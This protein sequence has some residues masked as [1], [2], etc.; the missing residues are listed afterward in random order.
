M[1]THQT[2]SANV[3]LR[4]IG[5]IAVLSVVAVF[6]AAMMYAAGSDQPEQARS[7]EVALNYGPPPAAA[8]PNPLI[9][10]S[11]PVESLDN[12]VPINN[13]FLM[14]IM[15]TDLD[16]V[17]GYVGFQGDFTFDETVVTF[18]SPFVEPAGLTSSGWFVSGNVLDGPG[19]IRILRVSAFSGQLIPLDGE[20]VLYN[21]R[22]QRVSDTPG[23][24]SPLIWRI[25]PNGFEYIDS[26]LN[27]VLPTQSQGR[28]TISGVGPTAT[29]T[30][31]PVPTPCRP[32]SQNFDNIFNLVQEYWAFRNN[33]EPHGDTMW[34]QGDSRVFP[35]QAGLS[36]AYI[37]ANFQNAGAGAATISNWMFTPPLDLHD[38]AV[39]TFYTR[40]VAVRDHPDRLQVRMSTND[41][42]VDVGDTAT[43]VGD[44]TNLLLDI[45]PH[46]TITGYPNIWTKYTVVLNGLGTRV[47]GRLAF[48]YFV[49]NAGPNGANSNWIGIDSFQ[50]TS[51]GVPTP[52]PTPVPPTP[53]PA[54][55][56]PTL[57]TQSSSQAILVNNSIACAG[58]APFHY[59]YDNSYWR[60]FD[61]WPVTGGKLYHVSSVSFGIE[62]ARANPA[63]GTQPIVVRLHAQVTGQFPEGTR[64]E[65][66]MTTVNLADQSETVLNV[67]IHAVVPEQTTQLIME[68]AIPNGQFPISNSFFIGS[69]PAPQDGPSYLSTQQCEYPDPIDVAILGFPNMHLVFNIHGECLHWAPGPSPPPVSQAINLSTRLRVGTGDNAGFIGFAIIGPEPKR[70]LIRGIG[71]SLG[72][73]GLANPL[74]DPMLE[75]RGHDGFIILSNDNWRDSQE[76]AIELTGV[77]PTNDLESAILTTLDPG[78]YN[79]ILKG[80]DNGT[81]GAVVEI[82]D[83]EPDNTSKLGNLSTRGVVG[84]G[85]DI[86]IAGLIVSSGANDGSF[87]LR[88][89]GPSLAGVRLIECAG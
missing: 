73:G 62:S 67:P 51:C 31:I 42:S 30:P 24:A 86:M 38:G 8:T 89:L 60:A 37:A 39:L 79:A 21:L 74:A 18:Q 17:L 71:P 46:Y 81:G 10:I 20:G 36:N 80:K 84:N 76:L 47:T 66:A 14:P 11:L 7:G 16:P 49:E 58:V 72:S 33:S 28:I 45:N 59:A 43:S 52:T 78:E 48:R 4:I 5:L 69:N 34:F 15:T 77:A 63:V 57:V 29:P 32:K 61:M 68:V 40:T 27:E 23:T 50:Y 56:C 41:L 44:F 19:P 88:G 75:L 83:L 35:A 3:A 85:G 1:Q 82:Y 53:T 54:E 65:I 64:R 22:V 70:V 55:T 13:V 25:Y 6:A 9:K 26:N 87:V 2:N 12:T